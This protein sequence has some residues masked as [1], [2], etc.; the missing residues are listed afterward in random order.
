MYKRLISLLLCLMLPVF[1]VSALATAESGD[2]LKG[3]LG[4]AL[5]GQ[6]ELPQSGAG[7]RPYLALYVDYQKTDEPRTTHAT[8]TLVH[9]NS[10]NSDSNPAAQDIV[11]ELKTEDTLE[12]RN[13]SDTH[14]FF[15]DLP[16][17][18][19]YTFSFDLFC[20]FP[21]EYVDPAP[22]PK[23]TITASSSNVGQCEYTCLFDSTTEPRALVWGWD[24]PGTT[25]NAIRNDLDMMSELFGKSYYNR[26]PV[27]TSSQFNHENIW[28][29]V[30]QLS[31][32]ETD[33]NDVTYIYLNAHGVTYGDDEVVAPGF[34]AFAP[35]TSITLDDDVIENE[36]I[37]LYIQLFPALRQRLKGRVVVVIDACYSGTAINRAVGA[38]FEPGQLSLMTS[39]SEGL[40]SGAYDSW[41]T[42]DYGW[43]TKELYDEF[44]TRT[45]PQTMGDAYAYMREYADSH[46]TLFM[47]DPQFTGNDETTLFCLDPDAWIDDPELV[48]V[49]E[50]LATAPSGEIIV[51]TEIEDAEDA[52]TIHKIVRPSVTVTGRSEAA[53]R[54]NARLG[55]MYDAA[56]SIVAE[57]R[58]EPLASSDNRHLYTLTVQ[59]IST[60]GSLLFMTFEEV[61]YTSGA[62]RPMSTRFS[63]SFDTTTGEEVEIT[64]IL[65]HDGEA[66]NA[67]VDRIEACLTRDH[68]AD[69]FTD[70]H[71]AAVYATTKP[72]VTWSIDGDGVHV[73][74]PADWI[75]PRYLGSLD[76]ILPFESLIGILD[77][78][79]LPSFPDAQGHA[80]II[81]SVGAASFGRQGA[82]TL[83][84]FDSIANAKVSLFCGD[85]SFSYPTTVV[86][87]A[88]AL[89]GQSAF[90]PAPATGEWYVLQ[91]QSGGQAT[92]QQFR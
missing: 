9:I 79:Y 21:T 14:V 44:S 55:A 56:Q 58:Q 23:L 52:S 27:K 85:A 59:D 64:D 78:A 19:A 15:D 70:A 91:Y 61:R 34:Y 74:Y 89:Y 66:V 75:T 25:P 6:T 4:A 45:A 71:T 46:I 62:A 41:L 33:E 72:Q 32:L 28:E 10:N 48:V 11:I 39:V 24:V 30:D 16:C 51:T 8:A 68:A 69:L 35:D 80:D 38:G 60:C 1:P 31:A 88:T 82:Y 81:Q 5:L 86:F 36:D 12:L 3:A 77:E 53:D 20:P 57:Q 73:L 92:E 29:L 40:V 18:E 17:G 43:F 76:V 13:G 7:S 90:L 54:I 22:E 67:L 83:Q 63:L 42:E 87:Y 47:M 49:E 37:V 65:P 84:A 26:Q 50:T 2:G